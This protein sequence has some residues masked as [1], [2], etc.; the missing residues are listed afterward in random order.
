M[1]S[2]AL[3][4]LK[5]DLPTQVDA[6]LDTHAVRAEAWATRVRIGLLLLSAGAAAR[7]WTA[8]DWSPYIFLFTAALWLTASIVVSMRMRQGSNE[9]LV[10]ITTLADFTIVHLG[11]IALAWTGNASGAAVYFMSYFPL[12]AVASIRYRWTLVLLAA[13]YVAAFLSIFALFSSASPWLALA[14]FVLTALVG[15]LGS[16][17][18]KDL[19]VGVASKS[20][21]EAFDIGA[22]QKEIELNNLFHE[23]LFPP[24]QIDLPMIWCASKHS[25]GAETGGDYYQVFD[26]A[27]GPIVIVGDLEGSNSTGA[28]RDT[29][30]LHQAL[31]RI[32]SRGND[33]VGILAQLN[34][35]FFEKYEGKRLFT[36][37]VV[38][39]EGDTM[40][41]ANAGHLPAIRLVKD[42]RSRLPV[43]CGPVGER[44]DAEFAVQKIQFQA[45]ELLIV[46]TDGLYRKTTEDRDKGIAEIESLTDKFSH[47]E[48]NT[49][50]HRIFD[51]AQPGLEEP[52]DDATIVV[53]RRQPKASEESKLQSDSKS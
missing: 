25:A 11:L 45:R 50:C 21:Q 38:R 16:G 44:R 37:V 46:Y 36:C 15:M 48:V 13:V 5:N 49:I 9:S 52:E 3:K 33:P 35:W 39:W 7:Y 51:C 17:K 47:G 30:L 32:T 23:A 34:E 2:I 31:V 27:A 6:A 22:R 12:L 8:G 4:R 1:D 20:L 14:V 53:I 19:M 26:T 41:Y 28:L 29:A 24:S 10:R 43:T 18:P 42:T 40:Y